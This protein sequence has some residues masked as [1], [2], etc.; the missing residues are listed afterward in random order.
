MSYWVINGTYKDTSFKELEDKQKLQRYGPYNS[1][2]EAKIQW[3]KISWENVDN[4][5]VRF[6]ILPHK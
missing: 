4:C 2:E 1:Y 5:F 6:I 3:D